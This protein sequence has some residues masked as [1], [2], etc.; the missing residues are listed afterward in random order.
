MPK[1]FL[2]IGNFADINKA[3]CDGLFIIFQNLIGIADD[4][5]GFNR[6]YTA[7]ER[8]DKNNIAS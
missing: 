4:V 6:H 7:T 8:N 1:T 5:G 3:T 2:D